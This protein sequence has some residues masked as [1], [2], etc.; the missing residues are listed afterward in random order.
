NI[1]GRFIDL[2]DPAVQ[3]DATVLKYNYA[4][5]FLSDYST[6]ATG[7][8]D[9]D[10][11]IDI[12]MGHSGSNLSGDS[13]P[14]RGAVTILFGGPLPRGEIVDLND[15]AVQSRVAVIYGENP[16]GYFGSGV[17]VDDF[18]GDGLDDVATSSWH[19]PEGGPP[20]AIAREFSIMYGGP[21]LRGH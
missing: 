15:S 16:D 8:I 18:N 2:Q 13:G 4:P 5:Q 3:A 10:G 9:G 19:V 14:Y 17:V 20:S 1:R 7:D 11:N 6:L 12:V 21:E